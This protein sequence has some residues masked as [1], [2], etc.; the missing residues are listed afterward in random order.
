M[1]ERESAETGTVDRSIVD[2]AVD[3]VEIGSPTFA[4]RD[5]WPLEAKLDELARQFRG[6]ENL[7]KKNKNKK[8]EKSRKI[9]EPADSLE[10]RCIDIPAICAHARSISDRRDQRSPTDNDYR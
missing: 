3:R 6:S 7:R 8:L 5:K 4:D 2:H 10:K 1:N 9:R